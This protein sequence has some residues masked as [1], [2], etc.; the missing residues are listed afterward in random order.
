MNEQQEQEL[1]K[2]AKSWLN[3]THIGRNTAERQAYADGVEDALTAIFAKTRA[4]VYPANK[5]NSVLNEL[6]DI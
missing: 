5:M 3:R 2:L 1:I 4:G 6:F